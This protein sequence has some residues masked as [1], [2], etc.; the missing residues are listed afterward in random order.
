MFKK[1]K[2]LTKTHKNGI[3]V[4]MDCFINQRGRMRYF[5]SDTERIKFMNSEYQCLLEYLIR[6]LPDRMYT[7]IGEPSW[8][9]FFT[10]ERLSL[11]DAKKHARQPLPS[12]LQWG[13]RWEYGWFFAAVEL[14]D[15]CIGKEVLL[16]AKQAESTVFVNDRVVGAFDKEHTHI[17]LTS[18]AKGGER[19]E[20]AMEVYA[21]HFDGDD[22]FM[23]RDKITLVFPEKE[24]QPAASDRLQRTVR[25]G[26]FGIFHR[27]IFR[28]WMDLQTLSDLCRTLPTQ[29]LRCAKLESALCR[30]CDALDPEEPLDSFLLSCD[31][32][33]AR[34]QK[35][36]DCK[37]GSTVPVMYAIGHSHLDLEWLWTDAETK[38]KIA[39]TVGNQ[40]QL[41]KEYPEYRYVQSQPWLMEVLKTDY[42]DLYADFKDA[43][44]QGIIT[45]EGGTWVEPDVNLPSGESLVRQFLYGKRFLRDEFGRESEIFWLPDSFGMS[46]SLP[47]IMNGC[48]IRYFMNAK[49]RW[50]YNGGEEYPYSTFRWRGIDGSETL[51]HLT[52][53]YADQ[54]LP[55]FV[56]ERWELNT[57]MADI[58]IGMIMYGHG[59]G[60]GG[61]TK[62]HLEHLRREADLEGMP[63]LVSASPNSFFRDLEENCNIKHVYE[64]ELYYTAHRGAYTTQAAIKKWNR[65]SEFALRE[66]EFWS[67][68]TDTAYQTAIEPLWK[69]LLF[70]Q[71]H[72]ILPGTSIAEVCENCVR[73]LREVVNGAHALTEHAIGTCVTEDPTALTVFNSLSWERTVYFP[74]PKGYTSLEGGRTQQIGDSVFAEVS[75]PACG[76]RS[77]RLGTAPAANSDAGE[78]LVLENR[79]LRAEFNSDGELIRLTD[80]IG[81]QECLTAPSNVF[82]MYRDMSGKFDAWDIDSVYPNMEV[83]LDPSATIADV[84]RGPLEQGIVIQKQLHCSKL[85]QRIILRENSRYLLFENELDWNETHKLLKVDFCTDLHTDTLYSE[86]QFG[87][88]DRP[89]HR[90]MPHDADRFEVCQ[91]KWSALCEAKR[92]VALLNDSKYGISSNGGTMSLTLLRSTMNPAPFADRGMQTFSYALMPFASSFAES[93]VVPC[94]YELNNPAVIHSGS[95]SEKTWLS[96]SAPNVIVDTVKLAEDGSGDVIVRMY[97]SV[98]TA[99]PCTLQPHFAVREAFLTD[100]LEENATTVTADPN[101][102]S[103]MFRGFEVKTVRLKR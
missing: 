26:S 84:Y 34:L 4:S 83:E 30:A 19:F 37:N 62:I 32:I 97:E 79:F 42:P 85:T 28:L 69:H 73:D 15:A 66:A 68:L 44:K 51:T 61:A 74:L 90:S 54:L 80:R 86:V 56:K 59:D 45:V 17:S 23:E 46:A 64:G 5:A 33:H 21:G 29:S 100:L 82:R 67:A 101:G 95:A 87:A 76:C 39:R 8:S 18:C 75:V 48:G 13:T 3:K 38:R 40:L 91:H 27:E 99:T 35:E 55:S 41:A 63:K 43:V 78:A 12:G 94:G 49:I 77:Y 6:H 7:P 20:I 58:P 103:L 88:I 98:N 71:F 50:Q 92:G 11:D 70:N 14:P 89:N 72:D 96:V 16:E 25:N 60:G 93:G 47:Q 81:N 53:G 65:R 52:A 1:Q 102:I 22:R 2:G 10:K 9:G 57:E 31:K 24:W 36:L